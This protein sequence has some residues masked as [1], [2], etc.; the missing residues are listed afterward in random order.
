MQVLLE[1]LSGLP[2]AD[3]SR[4][5]PLL[6]SST[7]DDIEEEA[8][9]SSLF[10]IIKALPVTFFLQMEMRDYI[11]DEDEEL[12]LIDFLDKKMRDWEMGHVE[13]I[14][15]LAC[16]CLFDRKNRRPVISQVS[17]K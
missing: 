10:R 1:I 4:E 7:K 14:Y 6:V 15:S 12:T 16:N 3:E 2:P 17:K 13:T 9:R 8:N 11:D 5:P